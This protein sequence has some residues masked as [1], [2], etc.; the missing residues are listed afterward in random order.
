MGKGLVQ[1]LAD[2]AREA[3]ISVGAV[4]SYVEGKDALLELALAEAMGELEDAPSFEAQGIAS[5]VP[6]LAIRLRKA[7]QWP[8]LR[9]ALKQKSIPPALLEQIVAELFELVGSRRHLIWLLD[10]C[11][12]DIPELNGLYEGDIRRREIDDFC[13]VIALADADPTATAEQSLAK[14]RALFEM[15][16]W[17]G[18][19]RHRD[20]LPPA[21]SN[22]A[23][24]EAVIAITRQSVGTAS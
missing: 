20:R 2:I 18:M 5:L 16:V 9:Q 11:A 19:H 7:M 8:T 1:H 24:L 21:V 14:G 6:A 13:A 4:Y 23:A 10:R 3:G 22:S 12:R 17:M 15:I